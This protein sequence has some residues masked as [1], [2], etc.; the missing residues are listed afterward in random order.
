[1]SQKN[2]K[3]YKL[4]RDSLVRAVRYPPMTLSSVSIPSQSL[5]GQL[6]ACL[7]VPFPPAL[8]A[9]AF[10]LDFGLSELAIFGQMIENARKSS[11]DLGTGDPKIWDFEVFSKR[12]PGARIAA[13][14]DVDLSSRELPGPGIELPG[15]PRT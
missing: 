6:R 14:G 13:P 11:G 10:P 1:M 12:V 15:V 2:Q 4:T 3:G 7:P 9:G 5:S 8:P